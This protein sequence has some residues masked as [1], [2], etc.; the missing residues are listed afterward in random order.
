MLGVLAAGLAG[1]VL[2]TVSAG[3]PGRAAVSAARPVAQPGR[4]AV[5]AARPVVV[6]GT[7]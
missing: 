6:A 3:Q 1:H 5:S 4:A 2:V 7:R